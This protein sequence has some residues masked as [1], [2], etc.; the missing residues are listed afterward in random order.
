ML[1]RQDKSPT[2]ALQDLAVVGHALGDETRLK[3]VSLL[4]ERGE[5]CVCELTE[6]VG[7]T[8]SNVSF[9]V[10]VLKNA[11][12]ITHKKLAKWMFYR[13]NLKALEQHFTTMRTLFSRTRLE[14]A[15]P[16]TT[17]FTLCSRQDV[18]PLSR[19]QARQKV[20]ELESRET[21]RA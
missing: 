16:K 13:I 17:I 6:T 19:K 15:R 20:T 18:V 7:T 5:T 12:L 21:V 8:Q 4:L 1:L 3:I 11:G 9:H 2:S 14:G 10:R